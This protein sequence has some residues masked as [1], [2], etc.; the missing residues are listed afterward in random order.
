LRTTKKAPRRAT[1]RQPDITTTGNGMSARNDGEVSV[2]AVVA[3]M[4]K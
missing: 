3:V 1:V 2:V 4:V